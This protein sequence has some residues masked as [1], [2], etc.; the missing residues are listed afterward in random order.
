MRGTGGALL[1]PGRGPG[2]AAA[3]PAGVAGPRSQAEPPAV[4]CITPLCSLVLAVPP[5]PTKQRRAVTS[6]HW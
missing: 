1:S 5:I 4:V 6:L 3:L 2:A